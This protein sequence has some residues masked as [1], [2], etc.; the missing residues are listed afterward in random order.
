MAWP[1]IFLLSDLQNRFYT[2]YPQFT[3]W[4]DWNRKTL[5][6]LRNNKWQAKRFPAQFFIKKNNFQLEMSEKSRYSCLINDLLASRALS[7]SI[8][9]S[10]ILCVEF[11]RVWSISNQT[12]IIFRHL[13]QSPSY[14][15][16]KSVCFYSRNYSNYCHQLPYHNGS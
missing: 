9:W 4:W 6:F 3:K 2:K 5:R 7:I 14:I 12:D 10:K 1:L 15:F 8:T 16:L 13:N 11:R